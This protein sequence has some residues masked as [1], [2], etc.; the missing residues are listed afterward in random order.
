MCSPLYL[1]TFP[2]ILILSYSFLCWSVSTIAI[3]VT[4]P[5]CYS[6]PNPLLSPCFFF[7]PR[8]SHFSF[9]HY[10]QLYVHSYLIASHSILLTLYLEPIALLTHSHFW[11]LQKRVFTHVHIPLKFSQTTLTPPPLPPHFLSPS[12][13]LLL[14]FLP[15]PTILE[16]VGCGMWCWRGMCWCGVWCA[17]LPTNQR[18]P[19]P[20]PVDEGKP[21]I[22]EFLDGLRIQKLWGKRDQL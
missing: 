10:L 19:I 22:Q 14:P 7:H 21:A 9:L 16:L 3:S 8:R 12:F 2:N 20:V 1:H 4:Y 6:S 11:L 18:A 13:P 5:S 17:D 15:I